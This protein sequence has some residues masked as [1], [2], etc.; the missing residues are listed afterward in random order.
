LLEIFCGGF[1]V[2]RRVAV[3][4]YSLDF[5]CG[6]RADDSC[7]KAC[8]L[9]S[10]AL[11]LNLVFAM[12]HNVQYVAEHW[13]VTAIQPTLD[14]LRVG[15]AYSADLDSPDGLAGHLG[16]PIEKDVLLPEALPGEQ[17]GRTPARKKG[18]TY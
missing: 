8:D 18:V 17:V 11:A 16:N 1:A 7:V 9:G 6:R 10:D 15:S 13:S 12:D 5:V 4:F 3:V 14:D 2:T